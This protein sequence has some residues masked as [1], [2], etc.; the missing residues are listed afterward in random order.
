MDVFDITLE[1]EETE[2]QEEVGETDLAIAE[3]MLARLL[4][5]RGLERCK[6]DL[7]P[8]RAGL[9]KAE[10][11]SGKRNLRRL[12]KFPLTLSHNAADCDRGT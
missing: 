8:C 4:V 2:L 6:N 12:R 11:V 3:F 5:R 7:K 1:V 9:K 10:C